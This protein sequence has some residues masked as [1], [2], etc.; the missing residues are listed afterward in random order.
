MAQAAAREAGGQELR[1]GMASVGGAAWEWEAAWA[2]KAGAAQGE[3]AREGAV[4]WEVAGLEAA[5][6]EAAGRVGG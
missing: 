4:E 2:G 1:E 6:R 5:E 3:A